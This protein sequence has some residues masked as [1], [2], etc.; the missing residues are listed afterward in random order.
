MV[1]ND[2]KKLIYFFLI[3]ASFFT[4]GFTPKGI[5]EEIDAN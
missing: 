4:M 2:L 3:V 5:I 1:Q